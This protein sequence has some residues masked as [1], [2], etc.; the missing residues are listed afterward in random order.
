MLP[1]RKSNSAHLLSGQQLIT[2]QYPKS[3]QVGKPGHGG[4]NTASKT[5]RGTCAS[6]GRMSSDHENEA[7][8]WAH[9]H[10]GDCILEKFQEAGSQDP[11]VPSA[12]LMHFSLAFS[13][14]EKDLSGQ[15]VYSD[16]YTSIFWS[17]GLF[18]FFSLWSPVSVNQWLGCITLPS[19]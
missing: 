10:R 13:R 12:M 18:G 6:E 17:P 2:Q 1:R 5:F 15:E 4:N 19:Q 3:L 9:T 7:R 14:M 11:P 8:H 16:I